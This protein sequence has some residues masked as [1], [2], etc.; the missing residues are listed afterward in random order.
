[1]CEKCVNTVNTVNSRGRCVWCLQ[2]AVKMSVSRISRMRRDAIVVAWHSPANTEH[3]YDYC[4]HLYFASHSVQVSCL[5]QTTVTERTRY[6]IYLYMARTTS[7]SRPW[8]K[9]LPP[10]IQV[11]ILE[12]RVVNFW[13]L[14]FF[15]SLDS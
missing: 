15:S 13:L 11:G 9:I 8:S 4:H 14:L 6:R 10:V 7:R 2:P 1:M 3:S 12:I 5:L